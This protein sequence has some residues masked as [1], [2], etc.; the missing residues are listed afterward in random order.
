MSSSSIEVDGTTLSFLQT[1]PCHLTH[2]RA[3]GEVFVTDSAQHSEAEFLAA[4]QLPRAHSLW[5]DRPFLFHDPLAI[6]EAGR[7]VAFLVIHRYL[8]VPLGLPFVL[9]HV[10]FTVHD[11]SG[12][13]DSQ[14]EPFEAVVRLALTHREEREG[15]LNSLSFRGGVY[16]RGSHTMEL[17]GE[18]QFVKRNEYRQLRAF[19]RRKKKVDNKAFPPA[20][21]P[22]DP[23][24][25]GRWNRKNIAIGEGQEHNGS[26]RFPV[27]VD[28]THPSFFDHPQDHL[29]GPLILEAYRQSAILAACRT[30]ALSSPCAVVTGADLK[31]T[32][33]GEFEAINECGA[34]VAK[35]FDDGSVQVDVLI[36]QLGATIASATFRLTPVEPA[37]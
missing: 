9:G 16:V 36:A 22:I 30:G 28:Q 34:R 11:L 23:Q 14:A 12:L 6:V 7:Q 24:Q 21:E 37:Y 18:L 35:T 2:R 27:I 1:V 33:F 3:V 29:P 26:F 4:M 15:V 20:P 5:D 17:G 25:L 10:D 31:F 8:D 19:A 13:T 32:E